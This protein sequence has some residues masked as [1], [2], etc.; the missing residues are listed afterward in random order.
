MHVMNYK[1]SA[2]HGKQ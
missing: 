2:G 1:T